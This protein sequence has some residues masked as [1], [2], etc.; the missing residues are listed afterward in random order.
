[1]SQIKVQP[2]PG[3]LARCPRCGALDR[4]GRHVCP[5]DVAVRIVRDH[6]V[7]EPPDPRRALAGKDVR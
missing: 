6:L 5:P 2:D 7:T 1:M 4:L 3:P